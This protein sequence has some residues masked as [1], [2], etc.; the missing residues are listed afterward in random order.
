MADEALETTV[1]RELQAA[2]LP[3]SSFDDP[4]A[5]GFGVEPDDGFVSVVWTPAEALSSVAF[6]KLMAG[7]TEHEAVLHMGRVKHLMATAILGILQS[8]G[9]EAR[10]SSDDMAPATVE[11][12]SGGAAQ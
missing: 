2:G 11:V 9:L 6:D 4:Q 5:G 12:R 8:A 7:E 3:A 10:M 1:A